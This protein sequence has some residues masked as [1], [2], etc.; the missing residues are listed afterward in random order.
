MGQRLPVPVGVESDSCLLSQPPLQLEYGPVWSRHG[1]SDAPVFG[2]GH[3]AT[4]KG[5]EG[6]SLPVA[7]SGS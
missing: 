1:P 2:S 7:G 6:L 3:D 5:R 4:Q